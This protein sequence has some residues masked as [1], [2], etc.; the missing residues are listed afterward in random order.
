MDKTDIIDQAIWKLEEEIEAASKAQRESFDAATDEDAYSDGKYDT[1]SL[2]SSYLAG[3]Q[4]QIVKEL[5]EALQGFKLLRSQLFLQPSSK[6]TGLGSLL[7]LQVNE[8][9]GWYFVGPGGGGLEIESAG[10]TITVVTLHSPLGQ[11]LA[12]RTEGDIADLPDGEATILA[13]R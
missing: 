7:Q 9:A 1:R 12:G 6:Q 3:G 13:V 8:S 5:G 4:A 11:S 2:E 10:E